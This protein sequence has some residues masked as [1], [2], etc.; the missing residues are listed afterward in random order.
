[1]FSKFFHFLKFLFPCNHLNRERIKDTDT[2]ICK[3]CGYIESIPC[4][5]KW[6]PAHPGFQRCTKCGKL[7][8]IDIRNHKHIDKELTRFN[9]RDNYGNLIAVDYVMKCQIC[10]RIITTRLQWTM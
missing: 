4:E 10:G 2:L 6:E 5:H 1:M 8:L 9:V 7:E 3:D